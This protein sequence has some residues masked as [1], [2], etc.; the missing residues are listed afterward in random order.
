MAEQDG[1]LYIVTETD[2]LTSTDR[3]VTLHL[4]GPRPQGRAVALLVPNRLRWSQSARD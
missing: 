2:L 3:G 1:T 4:L